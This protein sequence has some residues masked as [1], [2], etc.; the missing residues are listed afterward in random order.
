NSSRAE[1]GVASSNPAA[2][3]PDA[4]MEAQ[5]PRQVPVVRPEQRKTPHDLSDI[6][7]ASNAPPSSPRKNSTRP[8]I[9]NPQ[10]Q[11]WEWLALIAT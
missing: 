8:M 5:T 3:P 1:Q 6:F 7:S 9:A 2:A 10:K 4:V 11:A